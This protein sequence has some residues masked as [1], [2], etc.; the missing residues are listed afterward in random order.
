MPEIPIYVSKKK[1]RAR[2]RKKWKKKYKAMVN[3]SLVIR[4]PTITPD[5][6]YVKM[7]YS[8]NINLNAA[9]GAYIEQIFRGNSIQDPDF[10]GVGGQPLGHDQWA[11]FYNK[12]Q[13]MG[14][15]I[16][17][18]AVTRP[19]P[20]SGGTLVV[21]P[22]DLSTGFTG[23]LQAAEAPYAKS[24]VISPFNNVETRMQCY[25]GTKAKF[26]YRNTEELNILAALFGANPQEEF[27]W[28]V[29]AAPLDGTGTINIDL[30]CQIVYY[31]K[32]FD[33]KELLRS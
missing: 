20:T 30:L 33:R 18:R 15:K 23:I 29:S 31:V 22:V 26:G 10:S 3:N 9:G 1:R 19:T 24:K 4:G 17:I 16:T 13:V 12:Y 6:V 11:A 28:S 21:A 8:Q 25:M 5:S 27:F 14:S 7:H 32:L 2:R